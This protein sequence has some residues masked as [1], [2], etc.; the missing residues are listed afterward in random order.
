M[1]VGFQ[2][3]RLRGGSSTSF[4]F[5][6]SK[7]GKPLHAWSPTYWIMFS[8][9]GGYGMMEGLRQ[10]P[11]R[12]CGSGS[13][14]LTIRNDVTYESQ[15]E[16]ERERIR[17][18]APVGGWL[19]QGRLDGYTRKGRTCYRRMLTT[20]LP[21]YLG[22]INRRM[23]PR[24]QDV[25]RRNFAEIIWKWNLKVSQSWMC[26]GWLRWRSGVGWV[27]VGQLRGVI[28]VSDGTVVTSHLHKHS[29]P[30]RSV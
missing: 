20:L 9:A 18:W 23:W 15:K 19:R 8:R 17:C 13:L 26:S 22:T 12:T 21:E 4:N 2:V 7:C 5:F 14:P 30:P 24:H 3:T 29:P 6:P 27:G 10:P 28:G 16:W 1:I 25:L 11:S